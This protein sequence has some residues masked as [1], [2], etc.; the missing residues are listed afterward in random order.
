MKFTDRGHVAIR[1]H[2]R[3]GW[4]GGQIVIVVEDTGIGIAPDKLARVFDRYDRAGL[5][6]SARAGSGL[7]LAIAGQIVAQM[8]G[9]LEAAST[10]GEGSRFTVSLPLREVVAPA[11]WQRDQDRPG[12]GCGGGLAR[13]VNRR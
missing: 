7:G 12:T 1:A 13:Q 2:A 9:H 8:G 3:R 11:M 4:R 10:P 5:A 6:A